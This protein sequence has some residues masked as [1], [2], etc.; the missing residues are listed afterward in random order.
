MSAALRVSARAPLAPCL[1]A[2]RADIGVREEH[3]D[4]LPFLRDLY[5]G[6]RADELAMTAWSDAEK[7]RFSD[8]QLELQR[9]HYRRHYEGA[10]FLIIERDGA[11]I[12][13]IYVCAFAAEIR[14]MDI[15]VVESERD[16]GIGTALVSALIEEARARGVELT[17][18]VEP[19]NPAQRL[20]RRFGFRLVEHR[21]VY[22][23]LAW[24]PGPTA[25]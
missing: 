25:S 1:G 19:D 6:I 5:A 8:D 7:R 17:L 14:L 22:D 16:R 23:F 24:A 13:R 12:G 15:A 20:Y 9:I 11:A 18:H 3:A 10:E 2:A 4:D 21:G